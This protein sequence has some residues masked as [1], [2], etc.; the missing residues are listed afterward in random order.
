MNLRNLYTTELASLKH[1]YGDAWND[2][3]MTGKAITID[4]TDTGF[5][6]CIDHDKFSLVQL[7][8]AAYDIEIIEHFDNF[9]KYN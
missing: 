6:L 4:G 1:Y 7:K 5:F 3:N 8:F 2:F 9:S